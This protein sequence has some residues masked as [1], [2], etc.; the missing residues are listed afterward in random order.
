MILQVTNVSKSFGGVLA[1]DG[2]TFAVTPGTVTGLIGPNGAGKSTVVDM[3]SGFT[4]PDKGLIAFGGRQINGLRP[5]VIARLGLVRTFQAPREWAALSV[6]DNVLVARCQYQRESLWRT[7]T[8]RVGRLER[9]ERARAREILDMFG[10]AAHAG[11]RAATLS[12]GQ[13]RLL[14]FAR[15]AA[16]EPRLVVLDEP[17]GGVNP[18]LGAT[19]SAALRQFRDQGQTVLVVEHNLPFIE[20]TCDQ[21]IVMD[22]GEVIATGPFAGLRADPRV[23]DAYLGMS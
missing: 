11:Q 18:V 19:L 7:L 3:I 14:E 8:S 16:A 17:M 12:G 6:L 1:V 21:V 20:K 9:E 4:V 15:I 5:D 2:C 23:V 13:K 10:L 22:T